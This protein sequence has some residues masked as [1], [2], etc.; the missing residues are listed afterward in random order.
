MANSLHLFNDGITVEVPENCKEGARLKITE[1]SNIT[2]T[3]FKT[4]FA[5][6]DELGD[7]V[8]Y[9]PH[10]DPIK[11]QWVGTLFSFIRPGTTAFIAGGAI[12]AFNTVY[13]AADG[14]VAATGSVIIG[15]ALNAATSGGRVDVMVNADVS[16]QVADAI[17][18]IGVVNF[19]LS[20]VNVPKD[21]TIAVP[22]TVYPEGAEGEFTITSGTTANVSVTADGLLSGDGDAESTSTITVTCNG[23]T[24]TC[25][26]TVKATA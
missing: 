19:T 14:K 17:K 7:G 12:T 16:A 21:G 1:K 15:K 3:W 5:G 25:T 9:R 24:R 2:D 22:M 8:V 18:A 6:A 23:I 10:R 13:A 20:N 26:A 11:N 4:A